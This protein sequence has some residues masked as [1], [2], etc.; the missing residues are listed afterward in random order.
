VE[1]HRL[2]R[3]RSDRCLDYRQVD[4]DAIAQA[5]VEEMARPVDYMPV[6]NDD[7]ARTATLPRGSNLTSRL[8]AH[9]VSRVD[10]NAARR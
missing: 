5:L 2:D 7:P 4:A 10:P 6:A 3:H 9:P 8:C 1:Y